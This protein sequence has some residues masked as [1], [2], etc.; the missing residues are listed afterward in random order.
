MYCYDWRTCGNIT[1]GHLICNDLSVV[2][3]CLKLNNYNF[4]SENMATRTSSPSNYKQETEERFDMIKTDS[5]I[6]LIRF[7]IWKSIFIKIYLV[8]SE[9]LCFM[10]QLE[11]IIIEVFN[12]QT[13]K[14]KFEQ[15]FEL[16]YILDVLYNYIQC[17]AR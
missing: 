4:G 2:L 7:Y 11:L 15:L 13:K 9:L 14:N 16:I 5:R 8:L 6:Q 17:G 1:P 3:I 12:A 10:L